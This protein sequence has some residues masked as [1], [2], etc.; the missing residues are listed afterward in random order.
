MK[1]SVKK[2]Q[3]QVESFSKEETIEVNLQQ[4]LFIYKAIEEWRTYFHNPEHYPSLDEVKKF[5]GNHN[6]GM[7]SVL[8]HIYINVF[9]N[10]IPKD[11]EDRL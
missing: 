8:S 2:I 10:M 6:E 3:D 11:V 1:E 7:Y 5:I 9:G 4:L